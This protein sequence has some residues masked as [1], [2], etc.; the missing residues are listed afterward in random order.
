VRELYRA[1]VEKIVRQHRTT[2]ERV[3]KALMQRKTLSG[4]ELAKLIEQRR[5]ES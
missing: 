1:K 3:A 4:A 5:G 2:I